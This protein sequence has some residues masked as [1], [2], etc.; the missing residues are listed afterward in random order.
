M[1]FDQLEIFLEVARLSSFSRAAEKRFRTQPAVS[2]QIRGLEEEVGARL[3]DRSGGRVSLTAAGKLFYKYAEETIERRKVI[4]TEIAE[5]ERVPRGEIVVGANEG[6]CLHILPEVFA[7]FKR[8]Y[9]NVAVSI[10]RSDYAKILESIIENAVDFGVVSLPVTDNRLQAQLVHRDHLVAITAPTHPL[11]AKK[12]VSAAEVATY[13]LVL[14]KLGHTRDALDAL[15]YDHHLKPHLAMELDSSE[16]LKRFVAAGVGVGFI[17]RSNIEDDIRAKALVAIALADVKI[18]R[19]LALVFRKDKSL[20][21]A[22]RAFMDIALKHNNVSA[23]AASK[24]SR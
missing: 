17:A 2:A 24:R 15:F 1:D 4:V 8:D 9:P 20:S 7:Q 16:L 22:A 11:A 13:P 10:K 3:L 21:R 14:P 19:D 23:A 5:T 12:T 6:T 18:N